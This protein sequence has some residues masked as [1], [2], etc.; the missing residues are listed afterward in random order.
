MYFAD[1]TLTMATDLHMA[2]AILV[3][4]NFGCRAGNNH[5]YTGV[6]KAI[7]VHVTVPCSYYFEFAVMSYP[8]Q[9]DVIL[10]TGK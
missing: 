8:A 1:S 9:V 2:T 6:F 3:Y 7:N 4:V 5:L 10:V